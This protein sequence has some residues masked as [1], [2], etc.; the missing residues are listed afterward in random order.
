MP[1]KAFD[2]AG[3]PSLAMRQSGCPVGGVLWAQRAYSP[4]SEGEEQM[5][6]RCVEGNLDE[7]V[8]S[9]QKGHEENGLSWCSGMQEA[10]AVT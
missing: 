10:D 8:G 1:S 2:A 4:A 7:Q 9:F 5:L 3:F 6:R